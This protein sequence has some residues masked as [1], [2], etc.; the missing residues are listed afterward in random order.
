MSSETAYFSDALTGTP[1]MLEL[2]YPPS[3]VFSEP[4]EGS[5]FPTA[6]ERA[7]A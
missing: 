3:E 5:E 4:H 6:Q 1:E 7:L 2:G